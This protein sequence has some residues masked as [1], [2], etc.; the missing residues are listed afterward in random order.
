VRTP[1]LSTVLVAA[2]TAGASVAQNKP[3]LL[4]HPLEVKSG[5]NS[6]Q[7]EKLQDDF[8]LLLARR[9]GLLV[10]TR[11]AWKMATSALNRQDCEVRD[12][13]LRQLA[14]TGGTLYALY[15]QVETNAAGTEAIATGRVVSQDGAAVRA[16]TRVTAPV[17]GAFADA[18]KKALEALLDQLELEKLPPVLATTPTASTPVAAAGTP[19]VAAEP[20][21]PP[22]PPPA[23]E[24]DVPRVSMERTPG[25]PGLRAVA[26][27]TTIAAVACAGVALG[28]GISAA[29][30]RAALPTDGHL[31]DDADVQKQAQVNQNASVALGLGIGAGALGV[32]SAILYVA[33]APSER[34]RVS[35]API[36]GGGALA[37]SGRF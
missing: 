19:A 16:A 17:K 15:A 9:G 37:V 23:A 22:P 20:F 11:T 3:T 14:V 28:F 25:S 4:D 8:R 35:A 31:A 34:P 24:P 32:V 12:D 2:L 27:V 21:S 7:R 5:L 29:S 30:D 18:A 6:A 10:P 13:C 26:I 33:S 36:P 1:F